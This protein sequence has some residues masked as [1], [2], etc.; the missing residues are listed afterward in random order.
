MLPTAWW[1][2]VEPG[3]GRRPAALEVDGP[4]RYTVLSAS[5]WRDELVPQSRPLYF[6]IAARRIV[7]VL[8][9]R[10][11]LVYRKSFEPVRARQSAACSGT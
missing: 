2:G 3:R 8:A 7:G 1:W 6:A 5:L 9:V 10:L 4:L 11:S